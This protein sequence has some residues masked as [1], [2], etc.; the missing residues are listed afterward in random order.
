MQ[1]HGKDE[2]K[3]RNMG[4]TT[5]LDEK[6]QDISGDTRKIEKIALNTHDTKE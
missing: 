5:V 1:Q 2:R 6:H 3:D 4:M